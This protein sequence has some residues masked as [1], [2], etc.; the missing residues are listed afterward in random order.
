M[1]QHFEL[2]HGFLPSS[3]PLKQLP[4]AFQAWEN[5]AANLPKYLLSTNFR[6]TIESLPPFPE[7][8]LSA[9]EEERAMLILSFIGHAYVWGC[10]PVANTIPANLAKPWCA[11]AE[12]LQRPPILSYASY[13]LH[14]WY[15]ID[16]NGP[17][18]L[19]NIALLQ[20]FLGGIDEEWFVL[21]HI[22]IEEKAS[23]ALQALVPLQQAVQAHDSKAVLT[24]LKQLAISITSICDTLDRMPEHCDPYMYYNRVRPYIHGWKNNPSLPNGMI[25]ESCYD[26]KPQSL[27]G[28][29]GAQSSIIPALD[30]VFGIKH[31]QDQL[32]EYLLEMRQYMPFEHR[33][34]LNTLENQPDIRSYVL[35]QTNDNKD[36]QQYYNQCIDAIVR[37][38]TTHL[39]YAALYIQKQHQHESAN[40]NSVGTGGTPFMA[41]L[42]KHEQETATFK[43]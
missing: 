3:S 21:V 16:E 30:A 12:R 23:K 34:F 4:L 7:E 33:A 2:T 35:Q 26:N 29:T 24:Y 10:M 15:K 9:A 40:S 6:K 22:D 43:V 36:I 14:N 42:S 32:R 37:F 27:R 39:K 19:G 41:Y 20:N 13:A 11:V 8:Q 18:A 25:Y 38:R 1:S 28:E 17:I 31:K 5:V